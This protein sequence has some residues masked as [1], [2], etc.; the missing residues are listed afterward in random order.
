M[1]GLERIWYPPEG[2]TL[3]ARLKLS[4]LAALSLGFGAAV[5]LRNASFDLGWRTPVRVEGARVI[6]VGNLNVGGAGKTP[7]VIHLVQRALAK[8]MEVAVLSRGYGRRSAEEL[9][10]DATSPVT[11]AEVGDEPL[12]IA[13]R[14]PGVRVWVGA[15]RVS[16]AHKARAA[17]AALLVLD[18]GFQH[19][20]LARDA[21]VVVINEALGFGNGALLPRGP[22]REPPSSLRRA[23]LLWLRA[24][25]GPQH[26]LPF[27]GPIVRARHAPSSIR[28]ADGSELPLESLRGR[29]VLAFSALADPRAFPRTVQALGAEVV[30]ARP[31]PDHH[32][33]SATELAELV[34]DARARGAELIT[35]EK[36]A[37]RLP[38]QIDAWVLR[39]DVEILEGAAHLDA[40]LAPPGQNG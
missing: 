34:R 4:P 16:I 30:E 38:E 3:A 12:L 10:F 26:P 13:R 36:D 18:D 7:A 37:M 14:L 17:G 21:D 6:S 8:G 25:V 27:D 9:S 20:R 1:S 40:L 33:F 23:S 32:A 22:L 31:F 19:R 39:L 2:E 15:D 24:G 28:A 29:R 11:S 5:A 35:T